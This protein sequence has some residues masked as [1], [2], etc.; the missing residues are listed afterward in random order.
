MSY[1]KHINPLVYPVSVSCNLSCDYCFHRNKN[2]NNFSKT[3]SISNFENLFLNWV[4]TLPSDGSFEIIW[5]GGEP[6]LRGIDFYKRA[7]DIVSAH[8]TVNRKISHCL[9]TN[10]LLIDKYWAEFFK[11]NN[12]NIGLSVDG[13]RKIHDLYRKSR[14][15]LGSFER[16]M[17][18][19]AVLKDYNISFGQVAVVHNGNVNYPEEIFEFIKKLKVNKLQ[20][21]PCFEID[22]GK[23][24]LF[25]IN[26]KQ[27][28]EFMCKL[29]DLW[30]KEDNPEISIGYLDDIVESFLGYECFNCLLS[31]RCHNFLVLDWNG[32]VRPCEYVFGEEI[33]FGNIKE[34]SLIG[35]VN[36][37]AHKHFY[38]SISQRR[39]EVCGD[40]EWFEICKGGCP[41]HWV[42]FETGKTALCEANKIIFNHI[43][44]SIHSIYSK[45]S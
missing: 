20:I 44:S 2:Q 30:I 41:H 29:Y 12:F 22:N 19:I 10:G 28:G 9:Q 7:V 45:G 36:S 1:L 35:I 26:P 3:M 5:H 23:R 17:S 34:M 13:P 16:I 18:N 14:N 21:S 31:D 32:D 15:G 39:K 38:N 37:E 8:S 27:F 43:G 24:L 42:N 33:I 25:A 4:E 11:K 6:L 40:C